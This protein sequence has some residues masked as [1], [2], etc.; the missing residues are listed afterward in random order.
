VRYAK[1]AIPFVI[2]AATALANSG[3]SDG[4]E[5]NTGGAGGAGGD[6][7]SSSSSSSSSSGAG[8][9]SSSSS[10]SSGMMGCGDVQTDP[11][12]CGMCGNQCA[13]GQTCVAGVCTCGMTTVPFADVQA[14]LTA[15]CATAGCHTG[16]A[17]AKAGLDLTAGV[18]YGALVNKAT[19]QCSG[20]RTRVIPGDPIESY[21]VDKVL[22]VDL[23][24]T[25][26][27]M[28]PSISLSAAEIQTISD[29][30]CGGALEN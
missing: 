17:I 12:N 23:C 21:L 20:M 19:T 2:A 26:K 30:V 7:T 28:P 29:W 4:G 10:S 14:I 24:G 13:P 27:R 3:C 1:I 15:R 9:G 5:S 16:G 8:G 6:E 22:G 25:S 18:A 11:K